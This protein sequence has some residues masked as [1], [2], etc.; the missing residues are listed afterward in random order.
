MPV[1]A[2]RGVAKKAAERPHSRAHSMIG[3]I[4]NTDQAWFEFLRRQPAQ[5]EVN[6]WNPSG[7]NLF[8]GKVGSPFIFRLKAPVNMIG[9]FGLVSWADRMPEW[10]AWECFGQ[11]NGAPTVDAYGARTRHGGHGN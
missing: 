10:L 4:A 1:C 2:T 7:R 8:R 6:F 9:G 3:Y 11:G 5:E